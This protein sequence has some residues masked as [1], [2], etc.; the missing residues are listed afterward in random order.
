MCII[1]LIALT[2]LM[3]SGSS[4]GSTVIEL[5]MLMICKTR[6]HCH[7]PRLLTTSR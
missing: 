1:E 2:I 5:A 3:D 6:D 4:S 7:R